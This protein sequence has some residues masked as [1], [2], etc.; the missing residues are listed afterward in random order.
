MP[1][2]VAERG[3]A[4]RT[5]SLEDFCINLKWAEYGRSLF[6]A[7]SDSKNGREISPASRENLKRIDSI[8]D[9]AG[10]YTLGT[11]ESISCF[12]KLLQEYDGKF[13]NKTDIHSKYIRLCIK[14]GMENRLNDKKSVSELQQHITQNCRTAIYK[15]LNKH[16]D[17]IS[18]EQEKVFIDFANELSYPKEKY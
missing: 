14:Y 15:I 11:I 3:F 13:P 16:Y 5:G 8:L 6:N 4:K 12:E 2:A 10:N 7:Y 1:N 9:M 17:S 18:A